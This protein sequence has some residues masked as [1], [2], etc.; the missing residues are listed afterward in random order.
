[1]GSIPSILVVVLV[2]ALFH[3]SLSVKDGEPK[4]EDEDRSHLPDF[5]KEL[6]NGNFHNIPSKMKKV[7]KV[8]I[9]CF[10]DNRQRNISYYKR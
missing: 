7:L 4:R 8:R 6:T 1:M 9:R 2:V 10:Y 5:S 3:T